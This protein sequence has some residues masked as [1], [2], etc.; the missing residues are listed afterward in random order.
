MAWMDIFRANKPST[1]QL[2]KERL[3][4]IVAHQRAGHLHAPDY[5]P[6]LQTSRQQIHREHALCNQHTDH[7]CT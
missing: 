3:Q 1:A 5:L 2:A 4:V 6:K 7:I